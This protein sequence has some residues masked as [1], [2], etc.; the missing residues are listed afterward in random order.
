MHFYLI[1]HGECEGMEKPDADRQLTSQG[2]NDVRKVA[3]HMT[4]RVSPP[5][6]VFVS[7]LRRAQQTAEL[8]DAWLAPISIQE[9][10]LPTARPTEVLAALQAFE[11]QDCAL[12]GHLP[13]LGLLLGTLVWGTPVKE[14]VMAR[15]AAAHLILDQFEPGSARLQW[16]ITPDSIKEL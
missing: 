12:V 10:L 11:G 13:N 5:Q 14:I 9:W 6:Q 4:A 16:L 2:I 7:P 1:R 8:F 15:G 3:Q